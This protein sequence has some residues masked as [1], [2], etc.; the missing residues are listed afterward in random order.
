MKVMKSFRLCVAILL[1]FLM[2]GAFA[3]SSKWSKRHKSDDG[4]KWGFVNANDSAMSP[5]FKRA[6]KV[7]FGML[8]IGGGSKNDMLTN[9]YETEWIISP[10]YDAV[11]KTFSERLAAVQLHGRVGYV[12]SLNRMVIEPQ[13]DEMKNLDGFSHGLAAVKMNGKYGFINKKGVFVIRP[14]F[15]YA[16]NFR[17]N[18]LA[19]IK[20]NGKYGAINLNGEIV[21]ECK[22]I[23]EEA[24]ITV[25]I[26]NKLYKQAQEQVKKDYEDGK[27]AKTLANAVA[28]AKE[29]DKLL[30]NPDYMPKSKK[31]GNVKT[32]GE[33]KGY[34]LDDGACLLSPIYDD[35]VAQPNNI[36]LLYKGEKWGV[37]D[38]YG[39]IIYAPQF[40]IMEY[41]PQERLFI[42]EKDR[43]TGLY[44][45]SGRMLLPPCLDGIDKFIDGK[46]IAYINEENG[47]VDTQGELSDGIIERAFDKAAKADEAGENN[48]VTLGLYK[49]ILK[50]QPDFAMAHNNIGII[51]IEN[52]EY[53]E[54]MNRLKV[55]HK[56]EPQNTGIADNQ[57][58]AKKERN[59]RRWHRIGNALEVA[60]AV[61]TVAA[62][63]YGTV[64]TVKHGTSSSMSS[65]YS[66]GSVGSGSSG[67]G[68]NCGSIMS[69]LRRY[70]DKL[71]KERERVGLQNARAT[72][73]NAA[74]QISPERVDGATSGDYRV[75]NS[76]KAL[77]RSY[78]RR[79]EELRRDARK[80]GCM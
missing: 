6:N 38:T 57:H 37:A 47:L 51:E 80:R 2:S 36:L 15:D 41:I 65:G 66:S 75:I 64:E 26:S 67:G 77:I 3:D 7:E 45:Q 63:T 21:V 40:D 16:E 58:Q 17:P 8:G 43:R 70:E 73:K 61:V 60:A 12:D 34:Y 59:K 35:I 78:E 30:D 32:E 13:F 71:Q 10:Q 49:Q 55:A 1:T 44:S 22:F 9:G 56:L 68:G 29:I 25:P 5:W 52:K 62:A 31:R 42:V 14:E 23:A 27:F 69:E 19:S 72:G 4:D 20:K 54:G 24:M 50:A 48:S 79:V 39:R 33:A 18:H 53:K 76:G 28:A 74:H 46:A 11:A